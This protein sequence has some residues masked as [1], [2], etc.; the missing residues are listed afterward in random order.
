MGGVLSK[1]SRV[2]QIC[3]FQGMNISDSDEDN[4]VYTFEEPDK[5]LSD[6]YHYDQILT[7]ENDSS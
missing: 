6:I 3:N 7:I 5:W 2:N 4:H 1:P